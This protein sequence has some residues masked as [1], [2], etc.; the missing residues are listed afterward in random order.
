[1]LKPKSWRQ[2]F[3]KE[4]AMINNLRIFFCVILCTVIFAG[5][6]QM[7]AQTGVDRVLVAGKQ[8]L[9][10]SKIDKVIE[11]YE[12]AFETDFS[13]NERARFQATL[14]E[15]FRQDAATSHQNADI[16]VNAL[17]K[18]RTNDE[19]AQNKMR[20][21]FNEDFVKDLRAAND[22]ESALLLGIYERGQ[23]K[24]D[25]TNVFESPEP[26][27]PT[28]SSNRTIGSNKVVGKWMRSEGAGRGDDGTGKTIYSSGLNT[29]FE[30]FADGTMQFTIDKKVLSIT[31]CRISELTKIPGTYSF[32]GDQ[33]KMNLGTG[34]SVGTS[35]C[36]K[37]GNF[38]KKLSPSTLTKS[39]V[40]RKMQSV[41][42]PDE[43]LLLCLDGS[44]DD[45]ACFER[46]SKY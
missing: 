9:R 43:P 39:V 46:D 23:Q 2:I 34:T 11:F 38:K 41:F 14:I 5:V 35:S 13:A 22:E 30:F 15:A 26:P 6:N 37:A 19:A 44:T 16:L 29:T 18:I 24:N 4:K 12:W 27:Q 21:S 33:L 10:Q 7:S 3:C 28:K 25:A 1:M 32:D 17:A 45:N 31:Q 42:R 8:P 36:E 20:A 40:V